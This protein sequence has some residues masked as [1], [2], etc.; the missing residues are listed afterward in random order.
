[1]KPLISAKNLTKIYG[2]TPNETRAL[3]DVS[4]EIKK[5][6]FVAI[7]GPS[8][9]GK[10]TLMHILGCLDH[11]TSG[12]YFLEGKNVAN[13]S[14]NELASI[15]NQ[16]IG[17][18]FQFFNL[19]PRTSAIKNVQLPMIYSNTKRS[20]RE[21]RAKKLLEAVGLSDKL[22]STPAQLSGGQQ[23]RVAIARALV[24]N[25]LI[26]FADEPTGNLDTKSSYEIMDILKK[27]NS[28][29]NT[30]IMITHETDIAKLAKRVI[31]VRDG[32][33]VSDKKNRK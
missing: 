27:L 21:T 23:Q 14:E 20:E 3:D 32:K 1:M 4:F 15:R 16:N 22:N 12:Q 8:G 17:F 31:T 2:E 13:L 5:E 26:I 28:Q 18:V 25:P 24:N 33:I 29:G 6:E 9:S 19:L 7:I 10:S 30:I 11:P